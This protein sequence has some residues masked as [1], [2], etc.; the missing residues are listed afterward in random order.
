MT[1]TNH[2]NIEFIVLIN[3]RVWQRLEP[4]SQ[5][6][7]TRAART[8]EI[9]MREALAEIEAEAYAVAEANGM[10]VHRLSAADVEAW[11]DATRALKE[12]YRTAAGPLGEQLLAAAEELR[13]AGTP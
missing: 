2:S 4:A 9:E 12:T 8:V 7:I 6:L 11:Q 1:V 3:E 5:T 10:T 13:A